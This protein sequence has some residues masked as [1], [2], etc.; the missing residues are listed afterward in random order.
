MAELRAAGVGARAV[1]HRLKTGRLF[2]KYRGVY[3]IGRPDLTVWGERRAIVLACGT[4]ATLSHRSAAAACDR[5]P[6]GR[7]T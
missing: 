1:E 5:R 2:R 6:R 3:A 4:G 7:G